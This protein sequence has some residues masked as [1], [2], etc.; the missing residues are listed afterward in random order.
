MFNIQIGAM[1]AVLLLI[2][3]ETQ[4]F[5]QRGILMSGALMKRYQKGDH[6]CFVNVMARHLSTQIRNDTEM[7]EFVKQMPAEEL[8]KVSMMP[9]LIG[10][11]DSGILVWGPMIEGSLTYR[12]FFLLITT[13][14]D[15]FSQL[16]IQYSDRCNSAYVH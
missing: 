6:R 10:T 11:V 13:L 12:I 5:Y 1:L 15:T 7:I 14:F 16:C 8:L 9:L 4:K 3:E 2:N